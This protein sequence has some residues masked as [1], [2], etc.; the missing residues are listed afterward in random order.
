MSGRAQPL[1][2]GA[3]PAGIRAAQALVAAG[4]RPLVVDEAPACGG[5]IYRQR[6]VPDERSA[7]TLYGSEAAKA[8]AL[9][10]D[11]AG[12]AGRIDY[13]PQALLWNLREGVADIAVAG[14]SRRVA[15]D[16][17]ILATGATDR[18]LP[19][20]GWT[21][22]GVF[23]LGGAQI[24]LKS[25]GCA[26]GSRVVFVGSGPLLY[27]VAWQYM[28]AGVE[29]AAVLDAAPFSAKFSMLRGLPLFPTVIL[30][31]M[32]FVA[33]LQVRGVAIHYG[34]EDVRIEGNDAVS[35][36]AWK[37]GRRERHIVCDGVGYGLALRSETQAADLAGCAFRF[38]QRDRAW[39]PQRDATGRT[40]VP[41]V[42]LAGDGAGIA[43]ADAAERAGERAALA[44]CEDR[45]LPYSLER[46]AA[47]EAELARI[48]RFRDVLE[49][50]F[51]FPAHWTAAIA[52]DTM[53]CRCE[54]ISAADAR[55]AIDRFDISEI[56]RLKAVSRVGMGRC[57]GRICG[58]A[59]AELLAA[60]TGREPESVGRL[61]AQAPL[62]PVPLVL[63]PAAREAE[64]AR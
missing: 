16:G 24:A 11:F 5:Q 25:Q 33:E 13:W 6:L 28:K 29:V 34:V 51:P 31:G 52:G 40:S 64:A 23:T 3:G 36:V 8:Q 2:V 57:Q 56:N 7:K 58:S 17:L 20:P 42:Y 35:G 39:L 19:I 44:L 18:I 61:R 62:K 10:R 48:D 60:A 55:Q 46:A 9:H 21:L 26:I 4:L 54:E 27:L 22:P 32:R 37:Q 49:A 41:G 53:L 15:Y 63:A 43:G 14:E 47:L 50:A 1:V 59:A 12:L 45:R 38:D 30:R